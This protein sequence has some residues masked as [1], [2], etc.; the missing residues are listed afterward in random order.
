MVKAIE[1][2]LAEL[3]LQLDALKSEREAARLLESSETTDSEATVESA[4]SEALGEPATDN[5]A[6]NVQELFENLGERLEETNPTTI[7]VVFALGV[8][9]GRTL[10]K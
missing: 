1:Q 3:K 9:L 2:E 8:L 7:L 4:D 5:L 10:S 6:E